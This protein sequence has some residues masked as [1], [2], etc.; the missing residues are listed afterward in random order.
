M[1]QRSSRKKLHVTALAAVWSVA[2][3]AYAEL[4]YTTLDYGTTGTFLTGIRG[5]N[6]VGNYVIPGTGQTGGLLYSLSTG[7][8]APFPASTANGAN[9][10]GAIGSSPYGPSFGSQYGIL[11]AVGSYK[12][13]SSTPYD[14]SYL[15]DGAKAPAGRLTTLAYPGTSAAPTLNTIAHSTFGNQVVGNYDSGLAT[16]NAFIYNINT[17]AYTTNNHPG[18]VSTT[19]YGVWG[20]KI[21]GGYTPP[22]LGFERGYIYDQTTGVWTTYNHPGAVF[23]HFEGI[24]SAGRAGAYN[25]VADWA[26]PDGVLHA[27]VLHIGADGSQ[28]WIELDAGGTLTSA[29]SI[30]ANQAIGIYVDANGVTHGYLVS[31]PGIYDPIYNVGV[32]TSST[33]NT[34]AL[35]GANGD[36][37]VND[38]II[39]T[40]APNNS[41]IRSGTYGVVTNNGSIAVTGP[42]S[43]GV[44]MNGA[45]GTLRNAGSIAAAPGADAIRTGASAIGTMIIND[46]VIDGR[47]A[48]TPL[49]AGARFENSGWLGI[50]APGAGVAHLIG[51]TFVQTETGTLSVR[52]AASGND[53]LQVS[54]PA[55]LDGT[56]S[57]VPSGSAVL[58]IG[59]QYQVVN[60]QGGITGEFTT[61]TQSAGLA[62][63][64][65]VDT[66]YEPTRVNLVVTP[67]SYGDLRLAGRPQTANQS[68]VGNALDAIRPAPGASMTATQSAFYAP[69]YTLSGPAVVQALEQ[70]APTI[71]GDALMVSRD[72]WYLVA[73]AIGEQLKARRDGSDAGNAQTTSGP[74]GSTIWL[75]GLGQFGNVYSDA[76]PGYSSETGGVATGIDLLLTPVAILGAAFGFTHQ[77]TSARNAASFTGDAYQFELY[78]SFR[79]GIA[80]L[81]M[82]AGVSFLQGTATRPLYASGRKPKGNTNGM[83]GGGSLEAGVRIEAGGWQIEP[84]LSLSGVSLSQ[85]S[86]TETAGGPVGLSVASASVGSLQT[87]LG[88]RVERRIAMSD[89][90]TLVPSLQIGWLHEY[91]D[92][93][94]ATRASFIGAPGV[95]F[96]VQSESIGRDAAVIDVRAALDMKGPVSVYVG[97]AGTLNGNSTT[98]TVSA[99]V[100]VVW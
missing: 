5:N 74:H 85:D 15:Y 50:A 10:P 48:I 52:I 38:G 2:G 76:T 58:P 28:T 37:V 80:F 54:G 41:G 100:R 78:G 16:G 83:A 99:G 9:V 35:S 43:A 98:Q 23:T 8:W 47:V 4:T 27:S 44:E 90:V 49:G 94:G 81:E 13:E 86:L 69:L 7:V 20:D 22:G 29:N 77:D 1:T 26:G 64:T 70:F 34:P 60:A 11:N 56:L 39:R 67:S 36:D 92:T 87:L 45:Y 25:L 79:Q 66:L 89:T 59:Q 55:R 68:A 61:V 12:T 51:G 40:S 33:P 63:G 62:A 18:S 95:G 75:T 57:P 46:G 93:Q 24:T 30:Y 71:Y 82:Q 42:D 32:L 14:L 97:Y 17:G 21:A 91:L 19:A 96:G 53:S 31:I 73:G 84:S 65:R 6:I 88:T 72:N 3:P